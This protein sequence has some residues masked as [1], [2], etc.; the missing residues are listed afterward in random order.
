METTYKVSV[1]CYNCGYRDSELPIEKGVR[2][3]TTP[4]PKCGC[5]AL[6][7]SGL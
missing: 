7:R 6:H 1:Y 5:I 3:E 4:C 2:V